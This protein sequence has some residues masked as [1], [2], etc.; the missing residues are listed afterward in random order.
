[1][2]SSD[3]AVKR[4]AA[5]LAAV[6]REGRA[7]YWAVAV[8]SFFVNLLMLTGPLYMLNVYDRVLGSRSLETLIALSVLVA[9]LYGMMGI[10][11]YVRGR[12]MGRL[13]A[14]FQARL[15]R[16]VFAATLHAQTLNR[17]PQ[18]ART[19][20]R[21]LEAVQRLITSPAL[22]A[23][24]D[25]PF[26]PLFFAGIFV[27]HM[28]LGLL[29]L[30]GGVEGT[31]K[32]LWNFL[33]KSVGFVVVVVLDVVVPW[34]ELVVGL[35]MC[36]IDLLDVD[37]WDAQLRCAHERCFEGAGPWGHDVVAFFDYFAILDFFY[38]LIMDLVN[39]GRSLFSKPPLQLSASKPWGRTEAQA[40]NN[41]RACSKCFKC[42]VSEGRLV[43]YLVMAL[44]SCLDP[45]DKALGQGD[46]GIPDVGHINAVPDIHRRL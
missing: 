25:L 37:G 31:G 29:A 17:V 18:E 6:R 4:G 33:R 46:A 20:L 2:R 24:F 1:M 39:Y 21:D 40:L 34:V 8:F 41:S 28:D 43:S 44:A 27:F 10:L 5:E 14:R 45:C 15:D 32:V 22:M 36:G 38:K 30:V 13:G 26:I 12:V 42:K 16:R 3:Q 23:V 7:L 19:G 11:D 9:F 35:V